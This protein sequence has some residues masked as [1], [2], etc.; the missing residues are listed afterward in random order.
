MNNR[1]QLS[2]L[3]VNNNDV[4]FSLNEINQ[5]PPPSY[6]ESIQSHAN[7]SPSYHRLNDTREDRYSQLIH[8]HE[9]NNDFANRLK[10][11]QGFKVVFIF[12][13]SGSMNTVLN[14][15]PL[16]DNTSDRLATRWDELQC[17]ANIS[18]EIAS[19]FDPNGCD[20]YFLNR[21]PSPIK[22]VRMPSDLAVHFNLKPN[23][24]TPLA[25][26]LQNVLDD[27][28]PLTLNEKKLLIIIAT[29]GE[30]TDDTGKV[31]IK[32]F[33]SC[34]LKRGPNVFTTIVVCTD[35]D[36]SVNYLNKW[37][38][39]IKN[40]DVVDDFRN[41]RQEIRKVKGSSFKFSFGD[42]VVK[43]LIGSIDEELDKL[44]ESDCCICF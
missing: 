12:D 35:D 4:I 20:I 5:S 29:D 43:S 2:S 21:T 27:N 28:T 10:Q 32:Q 39:S 33:K 41:E 24:Y 7:K 11:L 17:F 9:I 42:Y 37:D 8:K 31:A 36:A 34:L 44:D 23:G 13:D 40:L 14:D 1:N 15:S 3:L 18:I 38:R 6:Q 26:V 19:V 22:H 30:P 25:K 16:N